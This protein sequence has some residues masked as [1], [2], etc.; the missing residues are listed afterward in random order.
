MPVLPDE[1]IDLSVNASVTQ[2]LENLTQDK[3]QAMYMQ[4]SEEERTAVLEKMCQVVQQPAGHMNRQD[5][6]YLEQQLS[7]MLGFEVAAELEGKRLNHSIGTTKSLPHLM[8]HPTDQLENHDA[9]R[10]AGI[11]KRRGAFGWFTQ[12]GQLTPT[13]TQ[14]EKYYF[15]VQASFIPN[16]NIDHV[17]LKQWFKF[18]KMIVINPR[19]ARAV[20]GVVGDIG[21]ADWMEHQ[22]GTSPEITREGQLWSMDA[23]GKVILLFINDPENR[24]SLGPLSLGNEK[25]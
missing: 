23:R 12:M 10:E 25:L 3:H 5:E 21:P 7:D 22:F 19:A 6:L 16:W 11:I 24:V 13:T 8:R 14:W 15:A 1:A 4:L 18:R 9:Y 17:A 2:A 20:V